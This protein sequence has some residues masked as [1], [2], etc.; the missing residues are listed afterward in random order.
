MCGT[1]GCG[2]G[3]NG[4]A[5]GAAP[6][7]VVSAHAHPPGP[8]PSDGAT[9]PSARRVAVEASLLADNRAQ[10][11]AL[12]ARL[13]TADIDAIGLVGG[14]GAGKTSLL[15]ATFAALGRAGAA[16]EAVVE[17]DCATDH[18]ARRIAAC[19]ARVVQVA[20]GSLCHLDAHLVAHALAALDLGGVRRLW[21]ENVGNLVC[22]APFP[23]GERR[24]VAVVSVAEGDDKPAKY[25]A[26]FAGA[27]LL[28]IA[29]VDLLPHVE[30]DV[31]RCIAAAR[32]VRPALPAL[33]VS[34]RRGD[35]LDAWLAWVGGGTPISLRPA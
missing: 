22:P 19:G 7:P 14:P 31:A 3:A 11:E 21:I 26:L 18:D 4:P 1:C 25:P 30:F 34:A 35:G 29:K 33:L 8:A 12:A 17:G 28:V 15:E 6:I 5:R 16:R 10:A 23:C 9:P 13:A 27:D 24:R 32:A 2:E 20:T